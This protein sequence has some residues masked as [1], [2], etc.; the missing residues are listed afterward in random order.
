MTLVS[1]Y[2]LLDLITLCVCVCVI[3]WLLGPHTCY[4]STLPLSYPFPFL[5]YLFIFFE[6]GSCPGCPGTHY[7]NQAGLKLTEICLPLSLECW[8]VYLPYLAQAY[9]SF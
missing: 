9:F 3:D 7:T 6:T 4:A 5:F 2:V 8:N 1:S